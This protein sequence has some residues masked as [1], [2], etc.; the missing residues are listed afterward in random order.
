M[1]TCAVW[2]VRNTTLGST[3]ARCP[4]RA[5]VTLGTCSTLLSSAVL[6]FESCKSRGR[7]RRH[8]LPTGDRTCSDLLVVIE[9]PVAYRLSPVYPASASASSA[10]AYKFP[11]RRLYPIS[12]MYLAS[13]HRLLLI[14]LVPP[15]PLA[16]RT[17]PPHPTPRRYFSD[18]YLA[19]LLPQAPRR[20]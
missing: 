11:A 10:S 18:S 17:T 1:S 7:P 14:L 20:P 5:L 19:V 6:S 4:S 3:S 13:R 9:G 2:A 12:H 8:R 16:R 15:C